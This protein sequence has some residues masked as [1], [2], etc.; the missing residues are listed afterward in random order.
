MGLFVLGL[1]LSIVVAAISFRY[2]ES[3]LLRL[4]NAFREPRAK[5]TGPLAADTQF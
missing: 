5:P 2:F 1:L 4:K 3:P